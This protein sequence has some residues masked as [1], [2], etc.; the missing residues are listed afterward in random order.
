MARN[1]VTFNNGSSI[2]KTIQK[3]NVA[4]GIGDDFYEAHYSE[5][6]WWTGIDNPNGFIIYSDTYSQGFTTLGD[7]RPTA[8]V[9]SGTTEAELLQTINRLQEMYGQNKHANLSDAITWLKGTGKYILVNRIYPSIVTDGLVMNLD[10]G[11]LDSY[12]LVGDTWY[13][14]SNNSNNGTLVNSPSFAVDANDGGLLDFDGTNDHVSISDFSGGALT[15]F[16]VNAWFK[17]D[18]IPSTNVIPQIITERYVDASN[19]NFVLGFCNPALDGKITGGFFTSADGFKVPTGFTPSAN[20]WYNASVTYD[21]TTVRLYKN[22]TQEST[23][24]TSVTPLSSGLG[25]YIARR[26]DDLETI[27]GKIPIVQVYNR[28]LTSTE[29]LQNYNAIAPRFGWRF[30]TDMIAFPSSTTGY[31]LYSGTFTSQDDGH[32]NTAITIP[33]F[34][35]NGVS[36]TSLYLGT[37]GYVTLNAGNGNIYSAPNA[38]VGSASATIAGNSSDLWLQ[39]GLVNTDGDTQNWYYKIDNQ[40]S[41]YS[42]KNIV[43]CGR[44][45]NTTSPRSFVLNLYRDSQYQY[46]E[47]RVKSN[48]EGNVGPYNVPS[49]AQAASTSSRVWRGDLNGQNW[50]YLGTGSVI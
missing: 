5:Y 48:A 6:K 26:W 46:V 19:I 8:W 27:D 43:Y 31:T 29:I 40:G 18:S 17:L 21:G 16:T 35:S 9:T 44:F 10:S 4:I 13:D 23:L 33:T 22:G 24:A 3:G 7:A 37:N 36:S 20:V 34:A 32:S 25:Y 14:F 45:G 1:P 42:I 38:A 2:P 39:K 49:V 28:A 47:T 15:N 50:T 30:S 41:K 11:F 12:P